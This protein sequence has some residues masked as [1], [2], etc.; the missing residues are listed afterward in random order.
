MHIEEELRGTLA[1]WAETAPTGVEL[2]AAT[3][4]RSRQRLVR[5]RVAVAGVAVLTVG[6]SGAAVPLLMRG[7]VHGHS[8]QAGS[9]AA[10]RT[11][12]T[13]PASAPPSAVGVVL[14]SVKGGQPTVTFPYTPTFIPTGLPRGAVLRTNSDLLMHMRQLDNSHWL[15]VE[16][17]ASQPSTSDVPGLTAPTSQPV[18]VRGQNGVIVTGHGSGA[19]T[20]LYWQEKPGTW[21]SITSVGVSRTDLLQYAEGL[22]ATPLS[23]TEAIHFA[24]LPYGMVIHES[25]HWSMTFSPA[26]APAS[27]DPP[28]GV[29]VSKRGDLP[30]PGATPV[31]V[32]KHKGYLVT[33][34]GSRS[35]IVDLGGGSTMEVIAGGL[36]DTDLVAFGAG[37]TVDLSQI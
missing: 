20:F 6:A 12:P 24:L 21:L 35:L 30:G 37:I 27:A 8:P 19:S 16:V 31:T 3:K 29:A 7:S 17:H 26:D 9:Q 10:S 14:V 23:H 22:R 18:Q 11:L 33:Q 28:V 4:V 15:K 13:P 5:R 34:D 2:L 32:G 25:L 1:E 36:S